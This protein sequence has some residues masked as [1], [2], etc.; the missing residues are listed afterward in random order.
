M[1]GKVINKI[2]E[3]AQISAGAKIE[4]NTKVSMAL[5]NMAGFLRSKGIESKTSTD[6]A[7][8]WTEYQTKVFTDPTSP[9]YGE[10]IKARADI[11]MMNATIGDF[12]KMARL[13]TPII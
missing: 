13:S 4:N 1:N 10:F 12:S 3:V 5:R 8:N 9:E 6:V 7:K 11:K 2:K